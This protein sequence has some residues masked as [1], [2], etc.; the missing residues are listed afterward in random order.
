M[1]DATGLTASF[2]IETISQAAARK[3]QNWHGVRGVSAVHHVNP[4]KTGLFPTQSIRHSRLNLKLLTTAEHTAAHANL[5][6]HERY[7]STAFNPATTT[8]RAVV[9]SQCKCR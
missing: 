8:G 3:G 6:R 1:T 4:L 9:A 5:V 2:L 7:L